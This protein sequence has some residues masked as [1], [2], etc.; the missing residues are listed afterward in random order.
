MPKIIENVKEQLLAEARKQITENGYSK[1]TI[2]SVAGACGLAVGT[3]YNY[4][5]SKDFL[6]ASFMLE[7]WMKTEEAMRAGIA[8]A[9]DAKEAVRAVWNGIRVFSEDHKDLFSDQDAAAD[10]GAHFSDKHGL[11]RSRIAALLTALFPSLPEPDRKFRAEFLAESLLSWSCTSHSFSELWSVL[12][13]VTSSE[14]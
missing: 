12:S 7:D 2:R 5:P 11:L 9:P 14:K 1:T 10:Y 6:I 8:A 3:V 4:F 13:L